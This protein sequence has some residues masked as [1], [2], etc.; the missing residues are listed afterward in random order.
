[1]Q[2]YLEVVE[3]VKKAAHV[4][5]EVLLKAT[6]NDIAWYFRENIYHFISILREPRREFWILPNYREN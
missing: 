6:W 5:V 3:V 4:V 2:L 1:M